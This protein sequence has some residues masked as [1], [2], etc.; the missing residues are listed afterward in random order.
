MIYYYSEIEI[1]RRQ[2]DVR[3][4]ETLYHV[5]YEQCR[6]PIP[7]QM[8]LTLATHLRRLHVP[9]YSIPVRER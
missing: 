1:T 9:T 6:V 7:R 4:L 8:S 3:A 2:I 5:T